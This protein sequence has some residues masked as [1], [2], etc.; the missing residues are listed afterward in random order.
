[1]N[2]NG[3]RKQFLEYID[4]LS[5]TVY[6]TALFLDTHP[7]D[8]EA[9]LY[10]DKANQ[11]LRQAQ[12]EY[13]MKYAPLERSKITAKNGWSWVSEPWPWEGGC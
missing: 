10:Y 13:A 11:L 6:E 1:M 12:K 4:A 2:N 7:D 8:M 9:K 5:I 3:N